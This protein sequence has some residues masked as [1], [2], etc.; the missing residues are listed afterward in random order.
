[1]KRPRRTY[2]E[3]TQR[4][5]ETP[6]V[7]QLKRGKSSLRIGEDVNETLPEIKAGLLFFDY[8]DVFPTGNRARYSVHSR[9][10]ET[11]R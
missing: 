3:V 4:F 7:L 6:G 10:H 1:M 5:Y 2:A 11:Y 9:A 8:T